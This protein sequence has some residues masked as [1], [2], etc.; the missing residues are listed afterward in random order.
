MGAFRKV[1]SM[2]FIWLLTFQT[3]QSVQA[4]V[5]GL[6]APSPPG[7]EMPLSVPPDGPPALGELEKGSS[8][9][10]A[11]WAEQFTLDQNAIKARIE[12]L[13]QESKS[14]ENAFKAATKAAEKQIE[15]KEKELEKL[16]TDSQETQVSRMRIL[17]ETAKIR[18]DVTEK[19]FQLLQSEIAD[20][21]HALKA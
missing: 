9:E 1:L 20:D 10:V 6:S 12:A 16:R 21:V 4:E 8:I 5:W 18:K 17:C 15:Q 14:R 19:T 13:K 2:G 3:S 11:A 7:E